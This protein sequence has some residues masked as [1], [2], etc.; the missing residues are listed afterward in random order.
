MALCASGF[1][2]FNSTGC[3]M[4]D[5]LSVRDLAVA[6]DVELPVM[7][8]ADLLVLHSP[9]AADGP[10]RIDLVHRDRPGEP[11]ISLDP[12]DAATL[13]SQLAERFAAVWANAGEGRRRAN[14]E[15]S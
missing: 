8:L 6:P 7:A 2:S 11:L 4:T 10:P 5:V 9:A 1:C 3:R 13:A 12:T 15:L 14:G